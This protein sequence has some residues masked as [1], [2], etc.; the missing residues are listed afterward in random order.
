MP[1]SQLPLSRN[2]DSDCNGHMNTIT[3]KLGDK[4]QYFDFNL[5]YNVGHICVRGYCHEHSLGACIF[6]QQSTQTPC[7]MVW[8]TIGYNIQSYLLHI[9]GNPNSKHCIRE[10]LPL[11]QTT[12]HYIS[13]G[14]CMAT[15]DEDYASLL[16][17]I[18][19]LFPCRACLPDMLSIEH[20]WDMDGRQLVKSSRNHS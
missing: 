17:R 10:V 18:V 13:V 7:V 11:L 20:I 9:Q 14:Q 16:R 12:P 2:N 8:G 1:L 6:E 4:M 3:D 5:S 15:H 19:S